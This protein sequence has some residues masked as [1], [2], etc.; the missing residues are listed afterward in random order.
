MMPYERLKRLFC[1][2]E[3]AE[4]NVLLNVKAIACVAL[5][6]STF[7]TS[8]E[9]G[10][11]QLSGA[12]QTMNP[13]SAAALARFGVTV[14]RGAYELIGDSYK[15][16]GPTDSA[17]ISSDLANMANTYKRRVK[18][19]AYAADVLQA[20]FDVVI[21]ASE[22][23][24][25]A[26]GVGAVPAMLIGSSARWATKTFTDSIRQQTRD[27]A[28]GVLSRGLEKAGETQMQQVKLLL[29]QNRHEDA[30]TLLDKHTGALSRVRASL[31]DDAE[32]AD[33]AQNFIMDTLKDASL[34]A[35]RAAGQNTKAIQNLEGSFATHVAFTKRFAR[36][37][38]TRLNTLEKELNDLNTDVSKAQADIQALQ[39]AQTQT[40]REISAIQDVLFEQQSAA[41]KILL[42]ESGAK[43][44]LTN[45]QRD[46][47]ISYY[48]VEK[49]KDEI[50][51]TCA[52][53]VSAAQDIA[54]IMRNV[55]IDDP[56]I[57]QAVSYASAAQ[58]ALSNALSGNY[59][60]AVVAV[61]GLF[62]QQ[63]P[64]PVQKQFE[65]VFAE[66]ANI[67]ANLEKIIDLQVKTLEQIG[68]LADQVANMEAKFHE[69]LDRFEFDQK[70]I[71]AAVKMKLW[72]PYGSCNAAWSHRQKLGVDS[73]GLMPFDDDQLR[74]RDV[75]KL[76]AFVENF[77]GEAFECGELL[78]NRFLTIQKIGVFGNLFSLKF[79]LSNVDLDYAPPDA[80]SKNFTKTQLESFYSDLYTPLWEGVARAWTEKKY[81]PHALLLSSLASPSPNVHDLKKRIAHFEGSTRR[82]ACG[83]DGALSARLKTLLC[84]DGLVL[85]EDAESENRAAVRVQDL[86]RD[87]LIRDQLADLVQWSAIG[88]RSLDFA[89][90]GAKGEHPLSLEDLAS[91]R[92]H[93]HGRDLLTG[94]L[95]VMDVAVA[96][97]VL[98]HGDL[99]AWFAKE[100][101]W[102][103]KTRRFK[104]HYSKPEVLDPNG[105][106][107]FK[108][109]SNPNNPMLGRNMLML[110]L[111]DVLRPNDPKKLPNPARP[112]ELALAPLSD[113]ISAKNPPENVNAENARRRRAAINWLRALFDLPADI[114]ISVEN[115]DD[116]TGAQ[117]QKIFLELDGYKIQMPTV[118]QFS[119]RELSYPSSV[120]RVLTQ[121]MTLVEHLV[122]YELLATSDRDRRIRVAQMLA[123]GEDS[124]NK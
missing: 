51:A 34:D 113:Y 78:R 116:G 26:S 21:T 23:T 56:R 112:Y 79:A 2:M 74:F 88:A 84:A 30:A 64:D 14:F 7:W 62:G 99:A 76:R 111:D 24:A 91:G 29:S 80:T 18:E 45:E 8:D 54:A 118:R 121:R 95:W 60:G 115:E 47:L 93:P 96:Q 86:M 92:G 35:I 31:K 38:N 75:G 90:G 72:E 104:T 25:T 48:K 124:S 5:V 109:V 123:G 102:D 3:L 71:L 41:T 15:G 81:G 65:R 19:G 42:L 100:A 87:P 108:A 122:D 46:R 63:R 39:N 114:N 61:T 37:T 89:E 36:T 94:A 98:L 58:N 13:E 53:V 44:D 33:L 28:Y 66:L 59:L 12:G 55:G 20:N 4:M 67:N 6:M 103:K 11:A 106:L 40:T 43:R 82:G 85:Q 9:V 69:R 77:Y 70:T 1:K 16:T 120:S 117:I 73:K 105:Q 50:V 110:I 52:R 49:R 101:L 107:L 32:A 22:V 83:A 119:T 10:G 57:N 27:S 17:Q 97:Q 68:K